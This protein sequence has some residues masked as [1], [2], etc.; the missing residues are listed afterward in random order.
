[1]QQGN[2]IDVFLALHVLGTYAHNQ[3]QHKMLSC[4]IW[5]SAPS[6]W[7]GGG[8]SCCVGCVYGAES[9]GTIRTIH[10]TY[11]TAQDNHPSKNSDQKTICYNSKSNAPDD[12]CMYP[13]HV[14]LR[15]H[16]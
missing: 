12:G 11:A 3:E 7:M 14:E 5:F 2:F 8:E 4:R 16:Q 15:M 9:H 6:F 13:K 10:T 1:M